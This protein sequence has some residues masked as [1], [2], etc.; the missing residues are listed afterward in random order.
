VHLRAPRLRPGL[1]LARTSF[2]RARLRAY[3]WGTG[4]PR[5]GFDPAV[6]LQRVLAR[7]QRHIPQLWGSTHVPFASSPLPCFICNAALCISGFSVGAECQNGSCVR[8][9]KTIH[10]GRYFCTFM[11]IAYICTFVHSWIP[12]TR[13]E[14]SHSLDQPIDAC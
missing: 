8:M 3:L 13:P 2:E 11:L 10:I 4:L 7:Q 5:G 14:Y 6:R 9:G 1:Q 12:Q